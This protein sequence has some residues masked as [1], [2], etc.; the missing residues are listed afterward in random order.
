MLVEI[1]PDNRG[2]SWSCHEQPLHA[3]ELFKVEVP[4]IAEDVIQILGAAR[5]QVR[6]QKLLFKR[7]TVA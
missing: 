7:T 2:L 6:A 1:R 4:E 5:D 3:D